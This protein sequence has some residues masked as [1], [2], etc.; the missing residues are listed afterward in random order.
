[1]KRRLLKPL[2]VALIMISAVIFWSTRPGKQ[3]LLAA[4][5][6]IPLPKGYVPISCG[7][8]NDHEMLYASTDVTGGNSLVRVDSA[9]G[10]TTPINPAS[11]RFDGNLRS[12]AFQPRLSPNGKW[13][14]WPNG[15]FWVAATLDGAHRL[16]WPRGQGPNV[17]WAPKAAWSAGSRKWMEIVDGKKGPV[18]AIHSIGSAVVQQVRIPG[19]VSKPVEVLGAS[20]EG[21]LILLDSEMR[22]ATADSTSI[23]PAFLPG[24]GQ[25]FSGQS[26]EETALSPQGDSIAWKVRSGG[27]D[28]RSQQSTAWSEFK[29][30]IGWVPLTRISLYVSRADGS[31]M[32][33]IGYIT[34]RQNDIGIQKLRW[35][36]G[37]N[38][39]SYFVGTGGRLYEVPVPR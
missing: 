25:R 39:I 36:P 12:I 26:I 1:L 29:W 31:D 10:V 4:S 30:Q 13:L 34:A 19:S 33:E 17:A 37:G 8:L 28:L 22:V 14:L 11:L 3:T 38:K 20:G 27:T 15:K 7:W 2:V 16:T 9:T 6:Q 32:R 5:R 18:V 21:R 24:N 35:E 23:S